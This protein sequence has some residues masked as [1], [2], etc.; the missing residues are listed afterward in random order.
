MYAIVAGPYAFNES[1]NIKYVPM[2]IYGRKNLIGDI[3]HEE[4]LKVTQVGM[5]F[6]KDL[7]GLAYPFK[8]YD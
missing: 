7:F 4:M 6:Y 5:R 1:N 3:N 2:I 8:K